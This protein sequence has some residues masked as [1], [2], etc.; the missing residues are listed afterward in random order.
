IVLFEDDL[1]FKVVFT[2]PSG[3]MATRMVNFVLGDTFYF[4]EAIPRNNPQSFQLYDLEWRKLDLVS[5]TIRTAPE[6]PKGTVAVLLGPDENSVILEDT[7]EGSKIKYWILHKGQEPKVLLAGNY[8]ISGAVRLDRSNFLILDLRG[9]VPNTYCVLS[10]A[11][12]CDDKMS[13][14]EI[15]RLSSDLFDAH[16]PPVISPDH[17]TLWC[18]SHKDELV[19]VRLPPFTIPTS[20]GV[21]QNPTAETMLSATPSEALPFGQGSVWSYVLMGLVGLCVGI[22]LVYVLWWKW[23]Q[24]KRGKPIN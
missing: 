21:S 6:I 20:P 24:S 9:E 12:L 2:F 7:S 15:G 18:L 22:V 16:K 4:Q 1:S 3:Y 8:H 19:K 23:R 13:L 10:L 17:S 11:T 14:T 5:K